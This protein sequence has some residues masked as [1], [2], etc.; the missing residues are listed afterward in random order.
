LVEPPPATNADGDWDPHVAYNRPDGGV[1][2]N[3]D[4]K[5]DFIGHDYNRDGIIDSADFDND[6][7]G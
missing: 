1:D 3:R 2:M 7:D 5:V 6:F 4:G